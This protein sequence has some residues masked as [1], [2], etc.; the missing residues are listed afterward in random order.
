MNTPHGARRLL[1]LVVA[2]LSL[3]VS[4]SASAASPARLRVVLV[5]DASLSMKQ[6]DPDLL[7]RLAARLVTDLSDP[8]DELTLVSFGTEAKSLVSSAGGKPEALMSVLDGLTPSESCTDYAKGLD[9]AARAFQGPRPGGERR[10]VVFLTDGEYHP[11]R[12]G[13]A[14]CEAATR[15]ENAKLAEEDRKAFS[16]RVSRAA[17]DLARRGAKVFVVGL[18]AGFE[19]AERS[20][21]LLSSVTKRTG[22]KVLVASAADRVP[23]LFA[24]VF[25]ALVGSPVDKPAPAT[26]VGFTVPP[27]TE[28]LHLVA[29]T[30]SSS[31]PV[32]FKG[33]A[34]AVFPFGKSAT[35]ARGP[36]L[37]LESGKR[38]RGYAL[39]H[40]ERPTPGRYTLARSEGSGPLRV[41]ALYDV[42]TT[43]RIEDLPEAVADGAPLHGQ[44]AL[45][46]GR[47]KPITWPAE[48]L[49]KVRF[50]VKLGDKRVELTPTSSGAQRFDF[51]GLPPRDAPYIVEASA[52]H[53]EGFLAVDPTRHAFRVV[54]RIPLALEVTPLQFDTMAEPGPRAS[55]SVRVKAPERVP[56]PVSFTVSTTDA[57]AGADLQF[58]PAELTF[59]PDAREAT[60]Q[61]SFKDPEAL[62]WEDRRYSGKV[63]LEPTAST[64][65]L[66]TGDKQF[67]GPLDGVLR[68]WTLRRW[69]EEHWGKLSLGI[70]LLLLLIWLVGR[71]VASKFPPKAR[72]HYLE[73]D[74]P[75]EN[76]S[77]I[78][79]HARHGAYRSAKFGFPL[80]KK[81]KKLLFVVAKG[82][83][84]EL[85]PERGTE[86]RRI[87]G[88]EGSSRPQQG[89]WDSHYRLGDRFEIWLTRS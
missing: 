56:V 22:G 23:E 39:W 15:F 18:G 35:D 11:A 20:R 26:S 60:V 30:D 48:Y 7:A 28:R 72:I 62:R 32:E 13:E 8:R 19:K 74:A 44:V 59:G 68:S 45:R 89:A 88:T 76:D 67:T 57:S 43:L 25:A 24:D 47:G 61:V 80:G 73:L 83:G 77:L 2:V 86:L 66:L 40:V 14:R 85:Q 34:G 36:A 46:S 75:F 51:P 63:V 42:G 84:F 82:R 50:A 1:L 3:L 6:N 9:A 33:P 71:A 37:R 16:D 4:A 58:E 38:R 53:A 69:L 52:E 27:D 54:H 5:L 17:E 10:L 49:S 41:W 64:A 21:A 65:P 70:G 81:A 55:F 12:A 29:R 78:K 31:L 87:D 79:R